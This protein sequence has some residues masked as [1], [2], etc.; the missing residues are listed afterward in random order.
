MTIGSCNLA[1]LDPK[2]HSE[3]NNDHTADKAML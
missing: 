3:K 2:D 1:F